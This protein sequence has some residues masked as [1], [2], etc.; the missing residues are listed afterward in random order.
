MDPVIVNGFV[1]LTGV[2]SALSI[3]YVDVTNVQLALGGY[4][5]FVL[6][7]SIR[8]LGTVPVRRA[9][10]VSRVVHKPNHRGDSL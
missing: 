3:A 5:I 2:A 7:Y 6:G 8:K 9:P 1:A 10:P 4:A